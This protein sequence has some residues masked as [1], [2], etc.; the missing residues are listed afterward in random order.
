MHRFF[1]K[2]TPGFQK[3]TKI[4]VHFSKSH[5]TFEVKKRKFTGVGTFGP[6]NSTLS[7]SLIV[8]EN[9]TLLNLDR[10]YPAHSPPSALFP[11][12]CP[13]LFYTRS[14]EKIPF[15]GSPEMSDKLRNE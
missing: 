10:V 14:R 3:W 7:S 2:S 9:Y 6:T 5:S 11:R 4:N 15:L 1:Q 13:S 8:Q 12:R